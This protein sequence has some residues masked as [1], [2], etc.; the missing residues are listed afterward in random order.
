MSYMPKDVPSPAKLLLTLAAA[1]LS[2]IGAVH[3]TLFRLW[4]GS[5]RGT[6]RPSTV[7]LV[8]SLSSSGLNGLVG[9]RAPCGKLRIVSTE[10]D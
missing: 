2:I 1:N 8:S 6:T 10:A 4:L 7:R 5:L 9:G 3:L